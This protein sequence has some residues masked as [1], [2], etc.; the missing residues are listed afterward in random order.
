LF[1]GEE[2]P[3]ASA[4]DGD[5]IGDEM[6]AILIAQRTQTRDIRR[7]VHGHAG[8]A[9]HE[10]LDD[11][12]GDSRAAGVEQGAYGIERVAR[13]IGR[14]FA[15]FCQPG[16]RRRNDVRMADQRIVGIFE[17]GDIG[18]AECA[19]GLA[20]VTIGNADEFLLV[21]IAAIAP[22]MEAHLQCDF[23]GRCAIGGEE[24]VTER[25]LREGGEALGEFDGGFVR[26][27]GE[28]GVFERIELVFQRG[29]DARVGV[30]KQVD[31]PGAD[32]IEIA[33][34]IAVIEPGARTTSDGDERQALVVFH[35][36]AGVPYGT[37]AAGDP[38]VGSCGC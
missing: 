19:D 10:R 32:G 31:P 4:T 24:G 2:S 14:F 5:F 11:E 15:W 7:I 20:M 26:A 30:A 29:V 22:R 16:V 8:R 6:H 9:L 21:A 37:Q 34:A 23:D 18:D 35:L 27:A 1:A 25:M 3:G 38:V 36:G 12:R 28:H 33:V 13:D 17:Q